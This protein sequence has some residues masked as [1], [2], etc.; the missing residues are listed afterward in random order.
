MELVLASSSSTSLTNSPSLVEQ[1]LCPVG[2][3]RHPHCGPSA[4]QQVPLKFC[5]SRS[6]SLPLLHQHLLIIHLSATRLQFIAPAC[7]TIHERLR[8]SPRHH[9]WARSRSYAFTTRHVTAL[10]VALTHQTRHHHLNGRRDDCHC[11]CRRAG[12]E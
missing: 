9:D 2:C 6:R 10:P 5:C 1:E 7:F 3:S 4:P 11:A 12:S 8:S